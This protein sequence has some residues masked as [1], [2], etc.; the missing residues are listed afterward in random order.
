MGMSGY[1]LSLLSLLV[2]TENQE[3]RFFELIDKEIK[4]LDTDD[5]KII[6]LVEAK[7]AYLSSKNRKEEVQAII[8]KFRHF[9]HFR[10][11]LIEQAIQAKDYDRARNLCQEGLKLAGK[12]LY[13]GQEKMWYD[14]LLKIAEKERN[15]PEIRKLAEKLFFNAHFEMEYYRK[16][17]RSY[18]KEEWTE[19]CERIIN[20]I[21]D[22]QKRRMYL[23]H[24]TLAKIFIEEHY[25]KRLLELL[26]LNEEDIHFVSEFAGVLKDNYP[27][28]IIQIFEKSIRLFARNT[29]RKYYRDLA[30]Y[31]D[32]LKGIQGGA[33]RVKELITYFREEYRRRPVM[34]EIL[35]KKFPKI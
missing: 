20:K 6:S 22:P 17:K 9:S 1:F 10:K 21:K 14:Y 5:Y 12:S 16:L 13:V 4:A 28:E 18:S 19:V 34:M 3:K 26:K 33:E 31:L 30:K 11:M 29:G 8:E 35:N 32:Q 23:Y 2:M 25:Y 15:I 24:R 27:T 7:C